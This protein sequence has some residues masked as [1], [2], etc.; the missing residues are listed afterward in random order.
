MKWIV[1][2]ALLLA[3][4][5]VMCGCVETPVLEACAKTCTKYGVKKVTAN[6]CECNPP[7]FSEGMIK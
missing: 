4:G 7:M 3:V 5:V 6:L 2:I 1:A